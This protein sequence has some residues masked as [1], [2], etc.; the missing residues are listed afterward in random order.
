MLQLW[1]ISNLQRLAYSIRQ[2][3]TFYAPLTE[4]LDFFGVDPITYTWSGSTTVTY[5]GGVRT[6]SANAPIFNF[7]GE[8][9]NGLYVNTGVSLQ[10]NAANVLN[11][12]STLVWF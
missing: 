12:A 9:A 5:R 2:K 10:F 7:S 11:N 6:I 1:T 8:T 4:H 3:I